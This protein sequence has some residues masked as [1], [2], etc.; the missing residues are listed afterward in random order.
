VKRAIDDQVKA[1]NAAIIKTKLTENFF[2]S[3]LRLG[4][5]RRERLLI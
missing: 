5:R 4:L 2:A 1:N 3:S